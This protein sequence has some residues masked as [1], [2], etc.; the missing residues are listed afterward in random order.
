MINPKEHT[1]PNPNPNP[2]I[3][4]LLYISV[5]VVDTVSKPKYFSIAQE[6]SLNDNKDVSRLLRRL[7]DGI[8]ADVFDP[9]K[10]YSNAHTK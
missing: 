5:R 4:P 10:N 7:A 9:P 6:G 2:I 3:A 1:N 8:E